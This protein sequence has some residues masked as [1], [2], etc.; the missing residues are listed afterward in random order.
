LR[1]S[2]EIKDSVVHYAK[3]YFGNNIKLYL[4]GSRVDDSKRGGD[5]DLLIETTYLHFNRAKDNYEEILNY[6]LDI[7][8]YE[9]REKIKTIDT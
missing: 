1:L 9:N 6:Q 7:E 3:E 4:F 5:I 2:K 8:I